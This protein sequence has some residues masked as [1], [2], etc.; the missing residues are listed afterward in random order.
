MGNF[1]LGKKFGTPNDII[2]IIISLGT[3]SIFYYKGNRM[4]P[5]KQWENKWNC[6]YENVR[7]RTKIQGRK[8]SFCRQY[9][10]GKYTKVNE[11]SIQPCSLRAREK[12]FPISDFFQ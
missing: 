5:S 9:F 4:S 2:L 1:S 8:I 12:R 11:L 10:Y 7:Q 6:Y 3:P